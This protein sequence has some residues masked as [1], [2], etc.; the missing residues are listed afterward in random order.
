[1]LEAISLDSKTMI[2]KSKAI[3]AVK[4]IQ[5]KSLKKGDGKNNI[6]KRWMKK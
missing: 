3:N 2:I 5:Q 1:M 4:L 6:W